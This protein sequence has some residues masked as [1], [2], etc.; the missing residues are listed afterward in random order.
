MGAIPFGILVARWRRGIDI[1]NYGSGSTGATNILRT[2]GWKASILVFAGDLL[3]SL[4]AVYL[5]HTLTGS[6]WAEALTGVAA[7]AGHCWSIYIGW[8]GGRG[9][10]SSLGALLAIQPWVAI[11][12]LLVA[13]IVMV[14]TRFASLGSLLGVAFGVVVMS[15]LAITGYVSLGT[16]IFIVGAP[17][18]VYARHANNIQRLIRGTERKIGQALPGV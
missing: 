3:K 12:C 7:I 15:Y 10:T 5:A 18:I 13:A 9:A 2:V 6:D 11:G 16:V 8:K 4:G 17:L 14:R 1:S